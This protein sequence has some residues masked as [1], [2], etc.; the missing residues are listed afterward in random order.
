[1]ST[2]SG[3]P[4]V[5]TDGLVLWLD[6]GNIKSY[7]SGSTT[8]TD[9]SRSRNN[10]ALISGPTFNSANNGS[11]VFNGISGY[12]S[13]NSGANIL[14]S[15]AYTK[16]AWFYPTT[17]GYNIISGDNTSQH[18]FWLQGTSNLRAG[19]NG[20]WSIVTSTTTL[21]LNTWYHGAVSFNTTTGWALYVN[22]VLE[23]T[24]ADVTTFVGGFNVINVGSYNGNANLFF[25]RIATAQVYNRVL[26]A[27]EVLQNY[28]ATKG[29]FNL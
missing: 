4:N 9:L 8:W 28:N 25:G 21:A 5:V 22:G 12:V 11:I 29:R 24:S 20:S 7:V 18:A 13:V 3:G 27:R 1:M 2:L 10:S 19:H 17:Y 26:T 14:S 6:A 16:V 23:A 15:T